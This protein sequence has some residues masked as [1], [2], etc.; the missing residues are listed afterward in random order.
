MSTKVRQSVVDA[1]AHPEEIN[2]RTATDWYKGMVGA[3]NSGD[4]EEMQYANESWVALTVTLGERE[5]VPP[6]WLS[7][8]ISELA[9]TELRLEIEGGGENFST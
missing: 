2:L 8:A 7:W 4:R 9:L 1:A 3:L 5:N 6:Y